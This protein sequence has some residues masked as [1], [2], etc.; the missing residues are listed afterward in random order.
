MMAACWLRYLYEFYNIYKNRHTIYIW[1]IFIVL[2]MTFAPDTKVSFNQ[3]DKIAIV[4][5][6][7]LFGNVYYEV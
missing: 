2:I 4:L 3:Y 7:R 5:N 6:L 1:H